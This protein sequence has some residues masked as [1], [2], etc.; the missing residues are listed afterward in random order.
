VNQRACAGSKYNIYGPAVDAEFDS[1]GD[2][3]KLKG[4]K[5][6]RY[7]IELS[8]YCNS[9]SPSPAVTKGHPAL[10]YQTRHEPHSRALPG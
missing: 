8:K 5:C 7:L 1:D 9:T 4:P 3:S 6:R 2:I 10:H